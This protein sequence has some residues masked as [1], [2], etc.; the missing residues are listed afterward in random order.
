M[1]VE[2]NVC[3]SPSHVIISTMEY[4][5][6]VISEFNLNYIFMLDKMGVSFM[7][8]KISS[9]NLH[10]YNKYMATIQQYITKSYE[11]MN[12]IYLLCIQQQPKSHLWNMAH[13]NNYKYLSWYIIFSLPL[14]Q[15]SIHSLRRFS[16]QNRKG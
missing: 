7:L 12:K 1:D 16:L 9:A 4:T 5:H 11:Y 2:I 15:F 6:L 3:F 13:T 14:S 10:F 8:E